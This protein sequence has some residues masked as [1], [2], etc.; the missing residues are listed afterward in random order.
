MDTAEYAAALAQ[1]IDSLIPWLV[2]GFGTA[3]TIMGTIG[4]QKARY[5][6]RKNGGEQ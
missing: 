2:V 3:V 1:T 6:S 4:C 5:S